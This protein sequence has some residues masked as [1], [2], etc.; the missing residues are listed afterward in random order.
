MTVLWARWCVP[1]S[2]QFENADAVEWRVGIATQRFNV[3]VEVVSSTLS[4]TRK[5]TASSSVSQLA[6]ASGRVRASFQDCRVAIS[7]STTRLR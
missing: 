2:Y 5:R 1:I 4:D 7:R 6:V 3:L